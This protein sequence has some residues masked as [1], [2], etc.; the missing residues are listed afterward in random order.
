MFYVPTYISKE[1]NFIG[2]IILGNS[3]VLQ[4]YS[5]FL[6]KANTV[7]FH[8]KEK[9]SIQF[10]IQPSSMTHIVISKYYMNEFNVRCCNTI[11]EVSKLGRASPNNSK[12]VSSVIN[13][14]GDKT[15]RVSVV[16]ARSPHR[17]NRISILLFPLFS[18]SCTY[19]RV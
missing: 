4:C 13:G 16:R 5:S 11:D 1:F 6:R 19:T 14:S 9:I 15:G 17:R 2:Q 12:Y 8:R 10:S 7:H 18:Y 3:A